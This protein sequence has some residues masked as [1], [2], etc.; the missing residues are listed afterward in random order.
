MSKKEQDFISKW[1]AENFNA[2][3]A[4]LSQVE[5]DFKALCRFWVMF[6]LPPTPKRYA[7][8]LTPQRMGE[9]MNIACSELQEQQ[10]L[11]LDKDPRELDGQYIEQPDSMEE[12]ALDERDIHDIGEHFNEHA[13]IRLF[14]EMQG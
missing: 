7:F 3:P 5:Q 4:A 8:V 9:L 6:N 14:H 11:E 12:I 1:M 2:I 10:L 13:A